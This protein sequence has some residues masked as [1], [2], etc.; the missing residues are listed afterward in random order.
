[1][2]LTMVCNPS[3]EEKQESGF[4][5]KKTRMVRARFKE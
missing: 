3:F 4:V 5:L 1:M 2:E